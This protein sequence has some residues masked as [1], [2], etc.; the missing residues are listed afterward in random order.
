MWR[1][2]TWGPQGEA[3]EPDLP[4]PCRAVD[5]KGASTPGTEISGSGM[6]MK[7]GVLFPGPPLHWGHCSLVHAP[8]SS[9]VWSR[10]TTCR[11]REMPCFITMPDPVHAVLSDSSGVPSPFTYGI[12]SCQRV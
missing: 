2:V 6:E 12:P 11:A 4:S 3:P 9:E 10:Q 7:K 1:G 8:A 5:G